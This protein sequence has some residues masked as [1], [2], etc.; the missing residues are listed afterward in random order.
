M[1]IVGRAEPRSYNYFVNSSYDFL[2]SSRFYLLK[3]NSIASPFSL[4]GYYPHHN[5]SQYEAQ[6]LSI[7]MLF[8]GCEELTSMAAL[9]QDSAGREQPRPHFAFLGLSRGHFLHKVVQMKI[10]KV[11][12]C[13]FLGMRP[14]SLKASNEY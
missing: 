12:K 14:D 13:K 5:I 9:N 4:H 2:Q 3:F 6:E 7:F 10:K 1:S 8:L 11:S